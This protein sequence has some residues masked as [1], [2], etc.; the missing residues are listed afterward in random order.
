MSK[1]T[2]SWIYCTIH[3]LWMV[4]FWCKYVKLGI[5]CDKL[6]VFRSVLDNILEKK[7]NVS[8]AKVL[9]SNNA[10][11]EL[12][13]ERFKQ[14][15][16]CSEFSFAVSTSL[17]TIAH[18]ITADFLRHHLSSLKKQRNKLNINKSKKLAFLSQQLHYM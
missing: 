15:L 18:H 17:T 1:P 11:L 3:W 16:S 9:L 2:C 13:I 7:N 10:L 6:G 5:Y 14:N 4:S 12:D 8:I